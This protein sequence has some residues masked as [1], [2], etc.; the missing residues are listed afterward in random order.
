MR[1][2]FLLPYETFKTNY[3]TW[4]LDPVDKCVFQTLCNLFIFTNNKYYDNGVALVN[5]SIRKI[6]M[7]SGVKTTTIKKSI[8]K[9][10]HLGAIVKSPKQTRNNK[11]LIGFRNKD[12]D[13]IYLL[14]YL[15][16]EYEEMITDYIEEQMVKKTK[17]W[18]TPTINDKSVFK[19]HMDYKE[20]MR[21]NI[22][23]PQ[24]INEYKLKNG[25]NIYQILFEK[26]DFYKAP[27]I[28]TK[29]GNELIQKNINY[30]SRN[31]AIR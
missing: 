18:Q 14:D 4:I 3:Y 25:K 29:S 23:K 26:D 16:K 8:D 22:N 15:I 20:F 21:S 11:Y 7:T 24:I 27:L 10:D 13:V 19:M 28:K 5:A 30:V 2:G 1:K 6:A 12:D 31:T 9:L 17:R